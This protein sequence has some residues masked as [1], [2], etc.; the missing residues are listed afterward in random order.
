MSLLPSCVDMAR[1]LSDARDS[2][3]TLGSHARLHLWVCE[4]CR[5]LRAQFDVL[6]RAAKRAPQD[7]SALSE[8]AK[9]RLRRL[10][11]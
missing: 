11:K 10:L 4:V 6:G 5:R 1:I 7:G 2:G 8:Q 3:R 9:A